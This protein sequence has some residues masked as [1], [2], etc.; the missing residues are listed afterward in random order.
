[1]PVLS[2]EQHT[3]LLIRQ[4]ILASPDAIQPVPA[5]K[6]KGL[7]INLI[8]RLLAWSLRRALMEHDS[9]LAYSFVLSLGTVGVRIFFFLRQA[10]AFSIFNSISGH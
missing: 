4:A 9:L 3:S 6:I 5:A 7:H 2:C 8:Y 10:L 1:M